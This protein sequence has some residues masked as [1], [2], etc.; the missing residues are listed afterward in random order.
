MVKNW[1]KFDKCFIKMLYLPVLCA[2]RLVISLLP[3]VY[4]LIF[5][6]LILI[7]NTCSTSPKRIFQIYIHLHKYI[8]SS[9][10]TLSLN[11]ILR[12]FYFFILHQTVT[13]VFVFLLYNLD[14]VHVF[15]LLNPVWS[16]ANISYENNRNCTYD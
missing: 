4:I 3:F 1:L 11:I 12:V 7:W 14:I 6:Y 8:I 2:I 13:V 15:W 10:F 9:M 16:Y 5:C